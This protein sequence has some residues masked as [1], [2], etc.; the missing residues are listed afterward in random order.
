MPKHAEYIYVFNIFGKV[1]VSVAS[2]LIVYICK[3][4]FGGAKT[5]LYFRARTLYYPIACS[6]KRLLKCFIQHNEEVLQF[7]VFNPIT[8]VWI[9]GKLNCL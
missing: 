8:L 9:D 4:V 5:Y 7:N 6:D 1:G 2:F 3:Y